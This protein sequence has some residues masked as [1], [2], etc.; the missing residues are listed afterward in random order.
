MLRVSLALPR[1]LQ[2]E[3][4]PGEPVAA[5]FGWVSDS[6]RDPGCTYELVLP[7][8][9]AL[10]AAGQSVREADLLPAVTLNLSWGE[11]ERGREER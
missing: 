1:S 6:L 3:F 2:G 4:N 8:R 7:S 10:E 9:K 11:R 5:V